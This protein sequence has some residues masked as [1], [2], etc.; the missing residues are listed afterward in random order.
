MVDRAFFAPEGPL[1]KKE[2]RLLYAPGRVTAPESF[3]ADVAVDIDDV[4]EPQRW[5]PLIVIGVPKTRGAG[6]KRQRLSLPGRRGGCGQ[7]RKKRFARV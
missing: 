7:R 2:T 1:L 3:P 6:D 4:I 5:M